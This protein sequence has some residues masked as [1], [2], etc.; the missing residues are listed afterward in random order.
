MF[1]SQEQPEG[2]SD[3]ITVSSR[4]FNI[5]LLGFALVFI[6]IIVLVVG[7]FLSGGGSGSVGGVVFIGPIPIVFG[8]GPDSNWL[9]IIS[10]IIAVVMFT[11]FFIYSR[12]TRRII[13]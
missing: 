10:I 3:G 1:E 6:G 5:L 13:G 9:I 7:A 4:L 2:Q 12:R 11:L 8:A